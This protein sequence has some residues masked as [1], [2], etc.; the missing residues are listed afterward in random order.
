M[1]ALVISPVPINILEKKLGPTSEQHAAQVP[2]Q[3]LPA[4]PPMTNPAQVL[5]QS[6]PIMP[7]KTNCSRD[8]IGIASPALHS[9]KSYP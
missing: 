1:Y 3:T 7:P 4:M 9:E 2:D 6:Q 8:A 5:D